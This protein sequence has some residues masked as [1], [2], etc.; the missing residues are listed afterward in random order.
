MAAKKLNICCGFRKESTCLHKLSEKPRSIFIGGL[1]VDRKH[2]STGIGSRLMKFMERK[3]RSRTYT[4]TSASKKET[5]KFCEKRGFRK[6]RTSRKPK[7]DTDV[8]MIKRV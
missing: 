2:Q 6:L 1:Y 5:I 4:V 8:I 3:E 7:G